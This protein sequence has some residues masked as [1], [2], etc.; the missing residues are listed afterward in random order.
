MTSLFNG[1]KRDSP[2]HK[3]ELV[4]GGCLFSF[5]RKDL[6]RYRRQF[7]CRSSLNPLYTLWVIVNSP[8]LFAVAVY[9]Y[10]NW[11]YSSDRN[12]KQNILTQF[13]LRLIYHVGSCL[14]VYIAKVHI[15]PDCTI[16]PGLY[17][18][19]KGN[20]IIGAKEMGSG[21]TIQERV[22]LGG[23]KS[24]FCPNIGD[25]VVVGHD[26]LVYGN[27]HIG[28]HVKIEPYTVVSG[29]IPSFRTVS[30]NPFE[31]QES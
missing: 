15:A 16:G 24:M 30:G 27:I 6:E 14:S 19:N 17:V 28:E 8:G 7:S 4:R 18:S 12:A 5:L 26:S 9:R 23:D 13:L 22:T 10:G 20:I 29:S 1:M 11:V 21:C 3:V 2:A 31:Y 25:S